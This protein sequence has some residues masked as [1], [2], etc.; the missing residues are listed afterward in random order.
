MEEEF[1]V[2]RLYI[3]KMRS[4]VKNLVQRCTILETKQTDLNTLM[5]EREKE[6]NEGRLLLTQHEAKMKSLTH[7]MKETESKKRSLEEQVRDCRTRITNRRFLGPL[8]AF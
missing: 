5:E 3:S 6:L 2:A 7:T 1:T 4:E 8:Y